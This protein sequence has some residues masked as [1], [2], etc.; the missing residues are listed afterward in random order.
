[1][2]S[3]PARGGGAARLL[4]A[5]A[6]RAASRRARPPRAAADAPARTWEEAGLSA[7]VA[8]ALAAL[9]CG[10]PTAI[11]AAAAA[12]QLAGRHTVLTAE[13]G[14]GKTYAYLAPLAERLQRAGGPSGAFA[15]V[16]VPNAMLA[17]QVAAA[18][19]ALRGGGGERL[20]PAAALGGALGW[21]AARSEAAA[22][23]VAT[24][25]RLLEELFGSN[26]PAFAFAPAEAGAEAG[27]R[28]GGWAAALHVVVADE[29]DMLLSGGFERPFRR[30]L[31][32][33]DAAEAEAAAADGGGRRQYIFAAAT[34]HASG[35]RTPGETL[36]RAFPDAAWLA[37]PR[38][39]RASALLTHV[40]RAV[41]AE[42]CAAEVA[43]A[44][45]E[46]P[47]ETSLVFCNTAAGVTRLAAE[48][49][50]AHGVECL[51]YGAEQ[52]AEARAEALAALRS[53]ATRVLVC[54]DAAARGLDV[55]SV[56]H[57][58]QAAFASSAVDFLHRAGRTCRAPGAAGR[59][60]SLVAPGAARLAAA[61][62]AAVEAG[63]GVEEEAAME[64]AFSRK[65]SFAKKFKKFGESRTGTPDAAKAA[66]MAQ[67]AEAREA[68]IE[69]K[70]GRER[71]RAWRGAPAASAAAPESS[72]S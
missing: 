58:V 36:S 46:A 56:T 52:G 6:L 9:G 5:R 50:A 62:R 17:R 41:A 34:M 68:R 8:A 42:E 21:Q 65:R 27:A 4:R 49:A 53:Q 16:L 7:P 20:L 61:V 10:T 28:G 54:T 40:W 31:Q 37:S 26:A 51:P 19:N 14:S 13:T 60:T 25:A 70:G 48:L 18:A 39:H 2:L 29:A 66:A 23:V 33:L 71:A 47:G 45:A 1:M 59:L 22:L 38:L 32:L 72:F 63:E 24:P 67:R 55:P 12:P 44:L 69:A 30:L 11:Q 35:R 64:S 57:V 15:A 43:A 3:A